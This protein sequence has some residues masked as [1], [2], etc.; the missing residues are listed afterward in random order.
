MC[1][2]SGQVVAEYGTQVQQMASGCRSGVVILSTV[3]SRSWEEGAPCQPVPLA[4]SYACLLWT[5]SVLVLL[6]QGVESQLLIS[7]AAPSCL[8][9][10]QKGVGWRNVG[11]K[12]SLFLILG[13]HYE[14]ESL[15]DAAVLCAHMRL[16]VLVWDVSGW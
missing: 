15:G 3:H 9:G 8:S 7:A 11:V 4:L 1:P 5:C 2:L 16:W 12:L 13:N 6:P 10:F 14:S